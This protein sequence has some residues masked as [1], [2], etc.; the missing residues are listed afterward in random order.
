MLKITAPPVVWNHEEEHKGNGHLKG[1]L[2]KRQWE[3][4][5]SIMKL[6]NLSD[7]I[8][9]S[10]QSTFEKWNDEYLCS[11]FRFVVRHFTQVQWCFDIGIKIKVFIICYFLL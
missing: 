4:P 6:N 11:Y 8:S 2:W 5:A 7:P 9:D 10:L 3:R 1:I